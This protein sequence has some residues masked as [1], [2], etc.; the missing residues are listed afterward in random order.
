M[1]LLFTA[2][3][4]LPMSLGSGVLFSLAG[5][6]LSR[7]GLSDARATAQ[8]A[9]TNTLGAGLGSLAGGFL[10][11]PRAG[12]APSLVGLVAAFAVLGVTLPVGRSLRAVWRYGGFALCAAALFTV[13]YGKLQ[14]FFVRASASRWM[15]QHDT[16]EEVREGLNATL[17]HI[18][19]RLRGLRLFD[20]LVTNAYSMTMNGYSGRR[21]MKAF[22][23][24]PEAL[25]PQLRRA[26]V[27]GYGIGNT[28]EALALTPEVKR[29]D[30][31][32]ISKDVLEI[33]RSFRTSSGK[34]PLDDPRVRVH[35]EDGR[36]FLAG[37]AE[38]YDLITGEPPPPVLAGVAN[39]YSQ[40]YFELIHARL[41]DGGFVTY[42]LPMMNLA[43]NSAKGVIRAFCSVFDNCTLWHGEGRN[44]ML[45]G[46]R[47]AP[48]QTV[49]AEHVSEPFRHEALRPELEAIGIEQPGIL[50]ALFIGGADYLEQLTDGT[51]PVTDNWPRR[52]RQPGRDDERDALVSEWM[53]TRA[54][55]QRFS[56]SPFIAQHWP[57]ELREDALFNFQ[58]R[59]LID[60]LAS[61]KGSP[62]R[63][64]EVLHQ[65]L[66]GTTLRLPVLLLLGSNPDIQAGLR[67]APPAEREKPQWLRHLIA[68]RLAAR[69]FVAANALLA[70]LPDEELALPELR[71]YV[72]TMVAR[73]N[74]GAAQP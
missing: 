40:E 13:P 15:T 60:D 6:G 63:T 22:V 69:D 5:V 50:G 36:Q 71:E 67:E 48:E 8:L 54:A 43:A 7:S 57:K 31:V 17:F 35:I 21:Y 42:W 29:I 45:V 37:T 74:S 33:S 23:M 9:F 51:D 46:S 27:I 19:H 39:L 44:F 30:I 4:V 3:L 1:V 62:A 66:H 56:S 2:P 68:N 41:A 70:R 38:R 10:L 65:V 53:D 28:A 52:L 24:L 59:H 25:H 47:G 34:N 64:I 61:P 18:V 49:S 72:A 58:T 55:R 20:Q 12:T 32:D 14:E 26:L 73:L 11:L 16:V